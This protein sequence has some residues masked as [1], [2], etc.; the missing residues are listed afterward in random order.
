MHKL[1][2][3]FVALSSCAAAQLSVADATSAVASA[4]E[5][6]AYA[7]SQLASASGWSERCAKASKALHVAEAALRG[8]QELEK[9]LAED[10]HL[11]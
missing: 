7:C 3:A 2:L 10:G 8:A 4:R 11:R 1:V 6:Q 9:A 5:K